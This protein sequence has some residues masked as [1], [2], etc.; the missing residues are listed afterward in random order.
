MIVYVESNFVLE[1][2]LVRDEHEACDRLLDL[3]RAGRVRL[4]LPAFSVGEPYESWVRRSRRRLEVS[5]QLADELEELSRSKPYEKSVQEMQTV[6]TLLTLS[7]DEEKAR[8]DEA[9]KTTLD[10]AELIP[11]D[12]EVARSAVSVQHETGLSPQDA[13]VYASVLRHL[14][15]AETGDKCFLTKNTR[16]FYKPRIRGQLAGHGC[17]LLTR[18]SDGLGFIESR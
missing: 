11:I 10:V 4:L 1:R 8:L 18:F 12:A 6:A 15:A 7:R 9:I 14:A 17:R 13:I 16:D 3:A 2:A 5:S